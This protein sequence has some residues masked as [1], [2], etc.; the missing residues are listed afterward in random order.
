MLHELS[1]SNTV[2]HD[3][4][5]EG[6]LSSIRWMQGDLNNEFLGGLSYSVGNG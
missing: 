4:I 1:T 6:F 5:A 3:E 2:F